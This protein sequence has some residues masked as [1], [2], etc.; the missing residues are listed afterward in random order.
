MLLL[1]LV[2]SCLFLVADA[3]ILAPENINRDWEI[4]IV[5]GGPSGLSALSGLGRVRRRALLFDSGEYR[6]AQTRNIH[7]VIGND[8]AVPREFR[9]LAQKQIARYNTTKIKKV[10]VI[11]IEKESTNDANN[12][13]PK[14]TVKGI[15]GTEHTARRIV[16]GTGLKDIFP[17]TPGII[18]NFGKGIFWCPWCDGWEHRDQ[19]IGILGNLSDTMDTVLELWNLNNDIIAFTNGTDTRTQQEE[20]SARYPGWRQTYKKFNITIDNRIIT[21]IERL[22]DGSTHNDP[23]QWKEFDLFRINFES[24]P[25][26]DR[27][28]FIAN[29]PTVQRSDLA[30]K[31]GLEMDKSGKIK[32]KLSG[33]MTTMDGVFAVGDCNSDGSTNIPHAMFSGKR[34]AVAIH[35][36]IEMENLRIQAQDMGSQARMIFSRGAAENKAIEMIGNELEEGWAKLRQ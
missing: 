25:S 15:D 11:S 16:L 36:D 14:F 3:S 19:S 35:L 28:A 8:G 31:M 13:G 12:A 29:F 26:I 2:V 27:G 33:M 30:V 1:G 21:S 24:G 6:N 32:T 23:I 18:Q 34:A 17:T 9:E 22:Q 5:G 4:I 20:L 10:K 7:D